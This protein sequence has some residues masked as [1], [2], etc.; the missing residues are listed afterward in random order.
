MS[1]T[2]DEIEGACRAMYGKSWDGPPEKMPG[3]AMKKVWRDL[4]RKA[5]DGSRE[6][7]RRYGCSSSAV[8]ESDPVAM[9]GYSAAHPTARYSMEWRDLKTDPPTG[10]DV[11]LLFPCISDVGILY[12]ASNPE[13]ARINALKQGY[14]HWAAI[15]RHPDHEKWRAY[16]DAL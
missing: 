15:E 3:E 10:G 9:Q 2:D 4:A 13:Y 14:T 11:V 12:T 8:G 1:A 6:A 5:I 16:C 7:S